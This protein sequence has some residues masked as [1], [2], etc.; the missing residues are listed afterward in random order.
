MPALS[1]HRMPR[2]SG[3]RPAPATPPREAA[4]RR[5]ALSRGRRLARRFAIP[6]VALVLAGG[7]AWS[8]STGGIVAQGWASVRGSTYDLTA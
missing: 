8:A 1:A 5:R 6:G 3:T 2:S 7:L 4:P